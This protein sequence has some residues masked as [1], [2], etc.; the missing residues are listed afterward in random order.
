D[1]SSDVCSSDLGDDAFEVREVGRQVQGEAMAHHGAIELDADGGD[2]PA[3]GPDAR[4]SGLARFGF[5]SQLPQI[6]DE[7]TLELLDVGGDGQ[8]QAGQVEDGVAHQLARAVIRGFAA[9]IGPDDLD[10]APGSLRLVPEDV[11][12]ARRL[13]HREDMRMLEE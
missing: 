13:A 1:W 10:P 11:V 12:G 3:P 7:R 4:Q 6:F 9:A 5:D 8:A 2:L